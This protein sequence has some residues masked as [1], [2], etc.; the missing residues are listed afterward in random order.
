MGL[1]RCFRLPHNG[2]KFSW[3]V[4]KKTCFHSSLLSKNLDKWVHAAMRCRSNCYDHS[5]QA[6]PCWMI[7]DLWVDRE[8]SVWVCEREEKRKR[9]VCVCMC[10]S[11]H[12]CV[13][14]FESKVSTSSKLTCPLNIQAS[15]TLILHHW[16]NKVYSISLRYSHQ[17]HTFMMKEGIKNFMESF[18]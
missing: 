12:V 3:K 16:N 2:G 8:H 1:P 11:V 7:I 18:E 15:I 9:C 5:D 13:C 17:T 4:K 14:V 10:V 6:L